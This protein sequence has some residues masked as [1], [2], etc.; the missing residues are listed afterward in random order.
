MLSYIIIISVGECL[1]NRPRPPPSTT[2][3]PCTLHS[4]KILKDD[5][6]G[7]ERDFNVQRSAVLPVQYVR[8]VA[9]KYLEVVAVPYGGLQQ[10]THGVRELSYIG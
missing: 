9:G 2:P 3:S 7:S 6:G 1:P 5:A 4:R 8:H 10:H